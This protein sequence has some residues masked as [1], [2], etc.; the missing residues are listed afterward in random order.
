MTASSPNAR[1]SIRGNSTS[2]CPIAHENP[3]HA[4][5]LEPC[6]RIAKDNGPGARAPDAV[7]ITTVTTKSGKFMQKNF[8][9]SEAA[10][11]CE[12]P[13]MSELYDYHCFTVALRAAA[14]SIAVN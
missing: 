7:T 12:Q 5:S 3:A 10:S 2:V 6:I 14:N 8:P 1:A 9:P 11:Y 4:P 13:I